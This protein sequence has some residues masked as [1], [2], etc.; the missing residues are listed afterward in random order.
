MYSYTIS[1]KFDKT[2]FKDT[3]KVIE[4]NVK[5]IVDCKYFF[6]FLDGDEEKTYY[7]D[8]EKQSKIVVSNEWDVQAVI[9]ESDIDLGHFLKQYM[10]I[11]HSMVIEAASFLA[12]QATKKPIT[13]VIGFFE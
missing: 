1:L 11:E 7:L 13:C 8:Y 4:E 5:N 12:A 9:V 6:D 3:C 10:N 2:V